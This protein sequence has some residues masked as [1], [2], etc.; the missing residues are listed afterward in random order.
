MIDA[1]RTSTQPYVAGSAGNA[2]SSRNGNA[3][4]ESREDS[5]GYVAG[6]A[7]SPVGARPKL[8]STARGSSTDGD[9]DYLAQM[10]SAADAKKGDGDEAGEAGEAAGT[11]RVDTTDDWF[12]MLFNGYSNKNLDG[13]SL[14][15]FLDTDGSQERRDMWR[16]F[17]EDP[18]GQLY[19]GDEIEQAGGFDNWYDQNTGVTFEEIMADPELQRR[20]F[21]GSDKTV[22]AIHEY[23]ASNWIPDI[24]GDAMASA[25]LRY[26]FNSDPSLAATV[27]DYMFA[28]NALNNQEDVT[29]VFSVNEMNNLLALDGLEFG[30]GDGYTYGDHSV[31]EEGEQFLAVD[32]E[33]WIESLEKGWSSVPGYGLPNRGAAGLMRKRYDT[34][35]ARRPGVDD[36]YAAYSQQQGGDQQ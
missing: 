12:E 4:W 23:A 2:V 1:V 5:N 13:M 14:G 31:P 10:R 27:M 26:L 24:L 21:G 19:Y 28:M 16:A 17:T 3:N 22:H 20:H 6:S 33:F 25:S 36:A 35:F 9:T 30:Y 7:S 29:D 18:L 11:N 32:P 8:M 15:E 34:G